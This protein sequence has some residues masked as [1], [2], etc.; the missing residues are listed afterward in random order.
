MKRERFIG[1]AKKAVAFLGVCVLSSVFLLVLPNS[2]FG[3]APVSVKGKDDIH[4]L[5]AGMVAIRVAPSVFSENTSEVSSAG[6]TRSLT[7]YAVFSKTSGAQEVD[8]TAY[9]EF[10][11]NI[12]EDQ[13]VANAVTFN[14]APKHVITGSYTYPGTGRVY[15]DSVTFD[16][17]AEGVPIPEESESSSGGA[18]GTDGQ[19]PSDSVSPKP[20]TADNA[21]ISAADQNPSGSGGS[22]S[23]GGASLA[24]LFSSPAST[25]A[26]ITYVLLITVLLAAGSVVITTIRRRKE[27]SGEAVASAVSDNPTSDE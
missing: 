11:S 24:A 3:D 15:E 16:V 22:S 27:D 12:P 14:S 10:Y 8:I 2:A 13:V 20:L 4:A 17:N 21:K 9:T 23:A 5:V 1:V 19:T 6:E 26:I 25:G 7:S 18:L